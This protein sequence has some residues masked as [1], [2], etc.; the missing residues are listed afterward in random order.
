MS[1]KDSFS[2]TLL[3]EGNYE[4]WCTMMEAVLIA[5]ELWD[6]VGPPEQELVAKGVKA[7]QAKEVKKQTA[8]VK[9]IPQL[10]FVA[11]MDDPHQVWTELKSIHRSSTVNSILSL[12]CRFFRMVKSES[13]TTQSWIS[14]VH[15]AG[16]Q[17]S[18]TTSPVTDLD[19]I[20]VI[21][22]GLSNEYCPITTLLDGLPPKE[23]AIS[24]VISRIMGFETQLT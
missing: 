3:V 9:I 7:V 16:I 6:V 4:I 5:K 23:L 18:H 19:I 12:H 24:T 1:S 13:E 8:H 17:L 11:G 15:A 22:E 2:V 21:T 10:P 14:C 20:L